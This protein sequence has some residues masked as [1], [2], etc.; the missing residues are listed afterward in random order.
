MDPTPLD[1]AAEARLAALEKAPLDRWVALSSDES[2][3]IAEG[4]SFIAVSAD[5]EATGEPDPLI[6]RV[7]ENWTPRIL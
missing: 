4:D 5:A 1:A 7:P 3:I 6:L 2:R